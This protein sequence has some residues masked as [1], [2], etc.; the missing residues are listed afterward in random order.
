MARI[1]NKTC[2][3]TVFAWVPLRPWPP[4]ALRMHRLDRPV[5]GLLTL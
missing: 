1:S 5:G 2:Y 4:E 3:L